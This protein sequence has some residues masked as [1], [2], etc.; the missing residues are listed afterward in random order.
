MDQIDIEM[1][2]YAALGRQQR[3]A[4]I[5]Q[6]ILPGIDAQ[7]ARKKWLGRLTLACAFAV[8]FACGYQ[9][10]EVFRPLNY[11]EK[12]IV[13]ALIVHTAKEQ[14][15]PVEAITANLLQHMHVSKVKYIKSHQLNDALMVL[16][17]YID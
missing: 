4:D 14:K 9:I 15:K 5:M 16:G 17:Q 10:G 12:M 11:S 2:E 3:I 6:S 7:K 1:P 8:I 13:Q